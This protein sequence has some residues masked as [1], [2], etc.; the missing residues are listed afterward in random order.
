M[1]HIYIMLIYKSFV[2]TQFLVTNEYERYYD[3]NMVTTVDNY[4]ATN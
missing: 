3:N 2:A 1:M 4:K